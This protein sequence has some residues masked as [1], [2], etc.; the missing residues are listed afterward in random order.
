MPK[1]RTSGQLDENVV[2]SR[3]AIRVM[4]G[5]GLCF[6]AIGVALLTADASPY[7]RAIGA[8]LV[9][10]GVGTVPAGRRIRRERTLAS[11]TP[12]WK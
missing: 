2:R 12:E 7:E 4:V 9:L 1:P 3:R 5:V 10:W 6:V 8:V 11:P